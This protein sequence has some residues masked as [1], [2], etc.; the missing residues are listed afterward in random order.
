MI[1]FPRTIRYTP[2]ATETRPG[3]SHPDCPGGGVTFVVFQKSVETA[4][5]DR[6][7]ATTTGAARC[8]AT[9][10]DLPA[11]GW[12][13]EMERD[14]ERVRAAAPLAPASYRVK[15]EIKRAFAIGAV[16]LTLLSVGIWYGVDVFVGDIDAAN[17]R[18]A[19]LAADPRPG[20]VF[21]AYDP[22]ASTTGG[23][24]PVTQYRWWIVRR[25][26]DDAL[27]IQ[28]DAQPSDFSPSEPD[29]DVG[30]FS[31]ATMTVQRAGFLTDGYIDIGDESVRVPNAGHSG[32]TT[33]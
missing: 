26:T 19:A 1:R 15:P 25:I 9:G 20:D 29:L 28:A 17:A 13:D 16:V 31:G 33:L 8:T 14:F 32:D 11:I 24:D 23:D 30:A 10:A 18:V 21:Q 22:T 5:S 4:F 6:T 12:T 3:L 7:T 27:D 2:I